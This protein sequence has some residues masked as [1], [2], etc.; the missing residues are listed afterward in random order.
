MTG[1]V[2]TQVRVVGLRGAALGLALATV[3][4]LLAPGLVHAGLNQWTSSGP[5][6]GF[7][8]QRLAVDTQAR[9]CRSGAEACGDLDLG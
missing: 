8:A 7:C 5:A 3:L 6:I 9:F 2:L 4:I 1:A